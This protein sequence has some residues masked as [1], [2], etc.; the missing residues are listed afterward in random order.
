MWYT[1]IEETVNSV[2]RNVNNEACL[3][4]IKFSNKKHIG[5]MY[6]TA[7]ILGNLIDA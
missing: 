6:R 3:I 4:L 5:L 2:K 1:L 7:F